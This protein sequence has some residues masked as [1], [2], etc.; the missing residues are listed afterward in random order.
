MKL[1]PAAILF[2]G[3]TLYVGMLLAAKGALF[4]VKQPLEPLRDRTEFCSL[5][6]HELRL[7]LVA[8]LTT[9]QRAEGLIASCYD[10]Y[11][12]YNQ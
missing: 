7:N 2:F 4:P 5:L 1:P 11:N 6:Q 3:G 9:E 12:Q 10:K 8:G